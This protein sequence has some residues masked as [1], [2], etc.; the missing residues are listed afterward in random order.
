MIAVLTV[1]LPIYLV[2]L[3]GF[4]TVRWGYMAAGATEPLSAFVIRICLPALIFSAVAGGARAALDWTF[5]TAY[6]GA[7]L[8]VLAAGALAMRAVLGRGRAAA[9]VI[10]GLGMALSNSVFVGYPLAR[11]VLGAGADAVFAWVLLVENVLILP[12][13]LLLADALAAERRGFGQSLVRTLRGLVTNPIVLALAAGL[14]AA[15][16]LPGLPPVLARAIEMLR[17]AAP[18]LAL[19]VVGA[20]A[21]GHRPRRLGAP[22]AAIA[23]GKLVAHPLAVAA[24][25]ASVPGLGGDLFRAGVIFAAC[26]M[27]SIFPVFGARF[28]LGPVAAAAFIAATGL[29]F[30]TTAAAI[31]LVGP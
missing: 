6:G 1:T 5:I 31:F 23:A 12:L 18:G 17:N 2:I 24:A 3:L 14:A 30:L 10:G 25:L 29:S 20:L 9:S 7:S 28:G 13:S 21:A 22:V 19:F 4:V 15:A 11:L 26:P 16:L 27:L 8:A